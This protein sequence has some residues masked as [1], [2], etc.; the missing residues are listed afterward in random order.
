G[1]HD[2]T[3]KLWDVQAG[4][5]RATL[6][7]H[8]EGVRMLA[9]SADGKTLAS[10]RADGT[11][12]L[13]DV[14]TA[15][16]RWRRARAGGGRGRTP[17]CADC[18]PARGSNAVSERAE[19]MVQSASADLRGSPRITAIQETP[20]LPQLVLDRLHAT[21]AHHLEDQPV[22]V[23]LDLGEGCIPAA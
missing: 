2:Q 8:S 23:P 9:F 4:K 15:P 7:G 16:R 13:W 22:D 1:S 21:D 6:R 11:I 10:G 3:V 14:P 18:R 5:E 12:K 17:S 20:H 19:R